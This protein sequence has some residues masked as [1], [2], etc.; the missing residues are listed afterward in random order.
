MAGVQAMQFWGP[1]GGVHQVCAWPWTAAALLAPASMR[2]PRLSQLM[3]HEH[4]SAGRAEPA[5]APLT[6]GPKTDLLW[7]TLH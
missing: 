4:C 2:K 7:L 3:W 6:L 1:T 5:C